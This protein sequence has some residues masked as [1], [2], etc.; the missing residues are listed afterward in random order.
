MGERL[1]QFLLGSETRSD[2]LMFFHRNPNVI[3]TVEGIALRVGSSKARMQK[4]LDE[5]VTLGVLGKRQ[6]G[7]REIIFLNAKRDKQI[8][9]AI[10]RHAESLLR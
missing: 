2:L 7:K 10:T 1:L 5:L 4:D 3:D 8:Q 9:E 6:L